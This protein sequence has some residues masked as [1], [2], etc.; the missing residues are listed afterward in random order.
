VEVDCYSFFFPGQTGVAFGRA[1]SI[2]GLRVLNLNQKA[3][4]TK[5]PEIVYLSMKEILLILMMIYNVVKITHQFHKC[6][7]L[8]MKNQ[9][10]IHM[11]R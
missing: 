7:A 9:H 8:K 6:Q 2:S 1:I 5:P 4:C 11:N 10:Q 3:A